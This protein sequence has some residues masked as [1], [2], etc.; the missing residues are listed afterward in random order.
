M[1]LLE[2]IQDPHIPGGSGGKE[3]PLG[4]QNL[5]WVNLSLQQPMSQRH[6]LACCA[7]LISGSVQ[8]HFG[9]SPVFL[10][11]TLSEESLWSSI[12]FLTAAALMMYNMKP[13]RRKQEQA[14]LWPFKVKPEKCVFHSTL[15][16]S[17]PHQLTE[18][19]SGKFALAFSMQQFKKQL[20]RYKL[21]Y[22]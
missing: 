2:K 7:S 8:W 12:K 22:K 14:I 5:C 18:A 11:P 9:G 17:V 19:C 1:S 21:R 13:C 4:L 6:N 3:A 15:S 10:L 16:I 20:W